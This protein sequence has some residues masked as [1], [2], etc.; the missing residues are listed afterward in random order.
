M[1]ITDSPN[2]VCMVNMP[3]KIYRGDYWFS[4]YWYGHHAMEDLQYRIL[5][6]S[7]IAH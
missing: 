2:K 4:K 5:D 3:R 6:F 1:K 7:N